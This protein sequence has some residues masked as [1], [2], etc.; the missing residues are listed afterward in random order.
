MNEKLYNEYGKTFLEEFDL[1]AGEEISLL[2]IHEKFNGPIIHSEKINNILFNDQDHEKFLKFFVKLYEAQGVTIKVVNENGQQKLNIKN[3]FRFN[4]IK[5]SYKVFAIKYSLNFLK[6]EK[7]LIW[8]D[9]DLR[10]KKKF[11]LEDLKEFL[12]LENELM[13]YLG[14]TKFPPINPYSECGF[15][16]FNLAHPFFNKFISRMTEIYLSGEIFSLKEWHDSWIWDH[17]R[18]EFEKSNIVFKNLSGEKF[19]QLEHPFVNCNLGK[20]FDHLKGP[21]KSTG[22]LQRR[23]HLNLFENYFRC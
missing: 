15:L 14:R 21:R 1:N 9:A 7:F 8:T 4:A 19:E 11:D 22:I 17:V 10:C 12:P 13:S 6:N 5:F 18:R 20:Y 2:N 16:V 23:L 3:D